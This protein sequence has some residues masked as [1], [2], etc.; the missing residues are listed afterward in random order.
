MPTE[1][2]KKLTESVRRAAFILQTEEGAGVETPPKE[3][4]EGEKELESES[5]E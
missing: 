5:Q 1:A 4:E 2:I 3:G